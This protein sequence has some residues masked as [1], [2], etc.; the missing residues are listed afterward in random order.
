MCYSLPHRALTLLGLTVAGRDHLHHSRPSLACDNARALAYTRGHETQHRIHPHRRS[1]LERPLLHGQPVLPHAEYRPA[2]GRR[3]DVHAGLR[4]RP[5]LQPVARGDLLRPVPGADEVHRRRPP[6]RRA[7]R[8]PSGDEQA[9]GR[10]LSDARGPASSLPAAGCADRGRDAEARRLSHGVRGQVALRVE[11]GPP[12]G[13]ARLGL[14]GGLPHRADGHARALRQG[15]HRVQ[16]QG[17]RRPETR[18][19]HDRR[20]D[21][22]R[23]VVHSRRGR[24]GAEDGRPFFLVLSHYAVHQP[25]DAPADLVAK[26]RNLPTTDHDNASTRPCWRRWTRASGGWLPCWR[27]SASSGTRWWSS[28]A[29]TAGSRRS[30]RATTR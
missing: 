10:Q 14:R 20:A 19:L 4:S 8:R 1:G 24:R 25:L 18:R 22:P 13:Q 30:P 6:A 12:A 26:Y 5:D 11:P 28:R 2:R 7:R 15:L 9:A 27:S 29:T 21:R 3:C 17:A 16:V 23:G